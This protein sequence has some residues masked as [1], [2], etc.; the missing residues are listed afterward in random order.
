M[1]Y[2]GFFLETDHLKRIELFDPAV[3]QRPENAR[4]AGQSSGSV[5]IN[6]FL[7]IHQSRGNLVNNVANKF[8]LAS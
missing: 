4:Q 2:R 8:S 6:N 1:G 5:Y 7:F 3:H